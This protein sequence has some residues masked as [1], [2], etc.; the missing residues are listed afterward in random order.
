MYFH[1][2]SNMNKNKGGIYF[3]VDSIIAVSIILLT[4]YL[5]AS[6]Y[7]E[8]QQENPTYQKASDLVKVLSTVRVEEL[9][10]SYVQA[11]IANG[12]IA[13]ANNTLLEQMGEFWANGEEVQAQQ[14]ISSITEGIVSPQFGVSILLDNEE[15]YTQDNEIREVLISSRKIITGIAKEKPTEG[16]TARVLLN[17]IQNKRVKSYAYFG[18]FVGDGI[19]TQHIQLPSSYEGLVDAYMEFSISSDFT[20][21]INGVA[22]G[23]YANKETDELRADKY[24]ISSAYFS[25]FQPGLNTIEITFL[26]QSQFIGG[27]FFRVTTNSTVDFLPYRYNETTNIAT[28]KEY[29]A[30]IDGVINVYSSFFVPGTLQSM[31]MHINATTNYPLFVSFGNIT[32]YDLNTTGTLNLSI[33][34][35][36]ILEKFNGTYDSLSGKTVPLRMGHYS[37]DK[38]GDLAGYTDAFI[39]TDVS[40]SM[41]AEDVEDAAGDS[42]LDVAKAVEKNFVDFVLNRSMQNRIGLV[43]Y[44][45][46]IEPG[47]SQDLTNDNVTLKD[48]IDGYNTKSGNTCFSCAIKYAKD[49]IVAQGNSSHKWAIILMSDGTADKCDAIPQARCTPEAAKNESIQYACD[50]FNAWN[51]SIYA[52]GFGVGADN[53]TLKNISEDCSD[54]QYFYSKNK[55]ALQNAFD[56]IAEE[57]LSLS[58]SYQKT[59]AQGVS[60]VMQPTSYIELAYIPDV[61]PVAYGKMPITIEED[62]FSNNITF[63]ILNVSPNVEVIGAVVTSYSS[64]KWTQ[65]ATLDGTRFFDLGAYNKSYVE[66]GDPFL[67]NIPV[68]L[69]HEGVNNI[70]I[71]TASGPKPSP[72]FGGSE[73]DRLIYTILVETS[74]S[75]ASVSSKAEGCLWILKFNDGS[76]ATLAIPYDYAGYATCDFALGD[77]D[78]NDAVNIAAHL[79]LSDLDF[80]SD[81]ILDINLN[82]QSLYVESAVMENVP[83]LWGPTIAE[84]RVWQ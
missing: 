37:S 9:N 11:L 63:G 65:N 27:G 60:S 55:S 31:Q 12:T 58:F 17:S 7:R 64:D 39:A 53:T 6:S 8:E 43:S 5:V 14:F 38:I 70:T 28:K 47:Q 73:D 44:H 50:A 36:I 15:M 41:D 10:N 78:A 80:D 2:G 52:I 30:G 16:Y 66:L 35:S 76:N 40:T 20:L 57:I 49:K 67:V 74:M 13:R 19:I 1:D 18:G 83:S 62:A 23:T 21:K 82:E 69:I 51:I 84:V 54:G 56:S 32:I 79:L 33:N 72:G 42:R 25:N 81:G 68:A 34:N 59:V 26:N 24:N 71:Q 29:L 48:K 4:L 22:S 46:S 75:F 45:S 61:S 3:T 77:Y